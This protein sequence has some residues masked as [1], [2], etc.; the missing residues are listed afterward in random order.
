[1][2]NGKWQHTLPDGRIQCSICPRGCRLAE[3]QPGFCFVRKRIKDRIELTTFGRTSG[4]A[5]DPIEKKPLYHF[6]PGSTV[7]SFG[8]PG[9]NLACRHCQNWELSRARDLASA[10]VEA[11][12]EEIARIA[13][14]EGAAS[15]AFTYNDPIV[16]HEYA[17]ETA[18][19]CRA[20]GIRT[21]AVTSGYVNPGPRTEFYAVIDA[22]NVDLKSFD[23]DFYRRECGGELA[24]VLDS[25]RYL[26]AE[27]AV[28][29]EITTLLIPGLNDSDRELDRLSGWIATELGP[30]VPLHFSA[31]HPAWR[32]RDR[33][34]TPVES[35]RRGRALA[36][37][38]GLRHVY[39]GNA[40]DSEGGRTLCHACGAVLIERAG[41][42][43]IASRLTADGRCPVCGTACAGIWA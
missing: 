7:L 30:D 29:L 38:N 41:F 19:A 34:R 14:R 18:L 33:G 31:F 11:A 20:L 17:I 40:P 27:T 25:L 35:L 43:I 10:G 15:V 37:A 26:H 1:M 22:A 3:G 9:C 24:P 21:V 12:P 39:T 4:L 8:T 23:P 32:R 2:K 5:L 6:L 42:A 36:Q 13:R 16:F 28:W